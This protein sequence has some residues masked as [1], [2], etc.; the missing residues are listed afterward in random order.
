M[1][2]TLRLENNT[3]M[4]EHSAEWR[5]YLVF[6]KKIIRDEIEPLFNK[7]GFQLPEIVEINGGLQVFINKRTPEPLLVQLALEARTPHLEDYSIIQAL[8]SVIIN[9]GDRLELDANA[10]E[11]LNKSKNLAGQALIDLKNIFGD[12]VIEDYYSPFIGANIGLAEQFIKG[13]QKHISKPTKELQGS[14]TLDGESKKPHQRI[15]DEIDSVFEQLRNKVGKVDQHHFPEAANKAS[16]LLIKLY[17]A[18]DNYSAALSSNSD[19]KTAGV[20]FE[21]ACEQAIKEATPILERDLGWGD[22]LKN[23]LKSIGNAIISVFTTNQ[24]AF[25]QYTKSSSLIAVET[26]LSQKPL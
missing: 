15:I 11:T 19:F 12:A 1:K 10:I 5:F 4:G 6:E 9:L 22:F 21:T 3:D 26:L 14:R 18:R 13:L 20:D 16:N 8:E 2:I 17:I 7:K 25:F 23:I 24:N